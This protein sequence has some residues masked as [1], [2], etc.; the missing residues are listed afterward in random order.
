LEKGKHSS[1]I[2][3]DKN[4]KFEIHP[5]KQPLANQTNTETEKHSL[6]V[7]STSI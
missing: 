3:Q 1:S 4:K 6:D 7:Q 2:I 5:Q